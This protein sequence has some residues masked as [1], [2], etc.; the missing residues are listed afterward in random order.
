MALHPSQAACLPVCVHTGNYS[1]SPRHH[2]DSLGLSGLTGQGE[3]KQG[4]GVSRLY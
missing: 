3:I 4:K 2:F 1:P